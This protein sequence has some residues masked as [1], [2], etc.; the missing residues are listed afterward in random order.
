MTTRTNFAPSSLGRLLLSVSVALFVAACGG[1][2]DGGS[3]QV[4]TPPSPPPTTTLAINSGNYLDAAAVGA[5][6]VDRAAELTRSLDR[7]F[8]LMQ[9]A[10]GR[11]ISVNC[12]GG[13]SVGFVFGTSITASPAQCNEGGVVLAGGAIVTSNLEVFL[14]DGLTLLRSGN[15]AVTDVAWR[16]A[17]GDQT[18]NTLNA[19]MTASRR[20]DDNV[21]LKGSF[22]VLRNAREDSYSNVTTLAANFGR[23]LSVASVTLSAA[24]PRFAASPLAI[25]SAFVNGLRVLTIR[26]SDGSYVKVSTINTGTPAQF[27]FEVFA[28]PSATNPVMQIYAEND[29]LYTAALARALQ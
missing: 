24:S 3:A 23:Q 25:D 11:N 17:S 16:L 7:A 12:L 18:S 5:V 27:K 6:A 2:G 4:T 8:N 9:V 13:G 20:A 26:A 29:P 21:D 1:G 19:S 22:R 28:S 14:R 10:E 15:F